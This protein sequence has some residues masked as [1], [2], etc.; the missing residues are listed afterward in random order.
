MSLPDVPFATHRR[1]F[2]VVEHRAVEKNS[3]YRCTST[4]SNTKPPP[5]PHLEP[6]N[7]ILAGMSKYNI[8]AEKD[9]D[10][11][12]DVPVEQGK[13]LVLPNDSSAPRDSWRVLLPIK[14]EKNASRLFKARCHPELPIPCRFRRETKFA[15]SVSL[16][17]LPPRS[18]IPP[19]QPRTTQVELA[20]S[21]AQGRTPG[22]L[23]ITTHSGQHPIPHIDR[24]HKE[25]ATIPHHDRAAPSGVP[26]YDMLPLV[27]HSNPPHQPHLSQHSYRMIRHLPSCPRSTFAVPL[28]RGNSAV[29]Q[30]AR[31]RSYPH[32][33]SVRRVE[34][35]PNGGTKAL[36]TEQERKRIE[37]VVQAQNLSHDNEYTQ[38]QIARMA[39]RM[40]NRAS[41]RKCRRK[42]RERANRLEL[43]RN[44]LIH[45]S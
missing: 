5:W 27:A 32:A 6:I 39:R 30:N 19:T 23:V 42:Q 34:Q 44:A 33:P 11:V 31:S 45:D 35:Q 29:I 12:M 8:E 26:H 16:P 40:L 37:A 18:R 2:Q 38:E 9:K 43:E 17:S 14:Q 22:A 13:P 36:P 25:P 41:V 24:Y 21:C 15:T 28:A 20:A 10:E 3:A 4:G 7:I 1:V